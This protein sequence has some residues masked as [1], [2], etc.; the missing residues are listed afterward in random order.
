MLDFTGQVAVVTGAGAGLGRAYA[1]DLAKR[2]CKVVV[3]DLGGLKSGEGASHSAAD[4]VVAEIKSTGGIA[5]ADYHSV[6]DGEKIIETAIRAFGRIDI[7][8]NNA[9]ILRDITLGKMQ[10]ADWDSIFAVHVQG[11]FK[12]THAAWKYFMS[13]KYGRVVNVTS[14]A[15]ICG[16]VGQANYAA[17]KAAIIGFTKSIA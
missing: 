13:Q 16:N 12:C 6:V 3:N 7:L 4:K 5:I 2:G 15:G 14:V 17:A 8:I 1:L 9:G 10:Q 11:T